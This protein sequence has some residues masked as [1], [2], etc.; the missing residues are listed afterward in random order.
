MKRIW[1][2]K[3]DSLEAAHNFEMEYYKALSNEVRVEA[4]QLLREAHFKSKGIQ[5]REDGKRL[6]RVLVVIKQA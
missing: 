4:V 5:F 3:A 2:N 1:I 6:R